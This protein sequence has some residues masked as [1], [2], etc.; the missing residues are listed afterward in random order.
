MAKKNEQA[1]GKREEHKQP[2][3]GML[4]LQMILYSLS[5][6]N[7]LTDIVLA[8]SHQLQLGHGLDR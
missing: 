4:Q 1:D 6:I 7:V 5:Q 2:H 3:F 8:K